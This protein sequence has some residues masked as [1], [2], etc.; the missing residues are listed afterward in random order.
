MSRRT[1]GRRLVRRFA[2][3]SLA[4]FLLSGVGV[5]AIMARAV[6]SQEEVGAAF[7]ARTVALEV[8]SPLLQ[9]ADYASPVVGARYDELLRLI[10]DRVLSDG[11][12]VRIKVWS[13]DHVI[14]F[15]DARDLV[16]G[17]FGSEPEPDIL[18]GHEVSH[19]SDLDEPENF[20]E[21]SLA[22]KLFETYVPVT[23]IPGGPPVVGV[24]EVYQRYAYV[25]DE[26]NHLLRTLAIVF[27]TG[28]AAL[29]LVLLPIA[30]R[31]A[32]GLR[33]RGER[34]SQQADQL[35]ETEAKYRDLVERL[36]A[37]VYAADFDPAGSWLYVS[38]QIEHI[39]GFTP[40]EWTDDPTLFDVRIH[41][42][43]E[44]RY[45]AAEARDKESG[46]P[47]R[48]EYR[49]LAKDGREVWLRDDAFV[50]TDH[51]GR[52]FLQGIMFDVTELKHAE[53]GLRVG[54]ER[55]QEASERLRALDQ[56]RNSFLQAVSHELR[57]PL[58][59]VL[60]FALTLRRPDLAVSPS[61]RDEMLDRLATNARKLE[62]LLSD[63]LDVDRLARGVIEP[64]LHAMDIG[65]LARRVAE[66]TDIGPRRL[67]IDA[68]DTLVVADGAK[69]ERIVENLLVNAARH[70]PEGS[71]IWLHVLPQDDGVVVAVEDDGPGVPDELKDAIF[72]PFRQGPP[73]GASRSG[74]GIGLSLVANFA[75]LHGGRAWVEDR[76]GGG[77][78]FRV[79][80]PA[81]PSSN[82]SMPAT[83]PTPS[84]VE[85]STV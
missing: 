81:D 71:Q 50:V 55:E 58:T 1:E 13:P 56:M 8:I 31:T 59:A 20:Q 2:M 26:V 3:G 24:V 42:D 32:R 72:E 4:A 29:Y 63:L 7:H 65:A 12:V 9:P 54:L 68:P 70:T 66:E 11:H 84:A 77:A 18:R 5:A 36:P 16:G 74:T 82:G 21:R 14:V 37:I 53:E 25:Q 43:D 78:S 45:R 27:G 6:R 38:P 35:R 46:G 83:R 40:Q 39:L 41:P 19:V 60:G 75:G 15:S 47:F 48:T 28:L 33:E 64:K 62:R 22:P 23:V 34:L 49:M 30:V 17:R 67:S 52:K 44:P 76:E 80:L 73:A 10:R 79:F 61:D 57:T 69:V 51:D 85:P